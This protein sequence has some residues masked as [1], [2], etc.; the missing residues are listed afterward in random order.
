MSI[1]SV[2]NDKLA[3]S[4]ANSKLANSDFTLVDTSSTSTTISLGE[5]LKIQGTSNEVDTSVVVIQ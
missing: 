1:K 4:I 5:T 2:A 3:G